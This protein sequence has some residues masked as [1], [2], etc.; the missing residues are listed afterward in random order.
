MLFTEWW[1]IRWSQFWIQ[2][3]TTD[4]FVMIDT[5]VHIYVQY[6]NPTL[7]FQSIFYLFICSVFFQNPYLFF[8]FIQLFRKEVPVVPRLIGTVVSCMFL[9]FRQK[10]QER[11]KE[12]R[13]N[14]ELSG[15]DSFDDPFTF[16]FLVFCGLLQVDRVSFHPILFLCGSSDSKG[17]PI[18]CSSIKVPNPNERPWLTLSIIWWGARRLDDTRQWRGELLVVYGL[19]I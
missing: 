11:K 10:R 17:E 12:V 18:E 15:I 7:E 2:P 8:F 1:T 19:T 9:C 13:R 5:I 6:L 3:T 16:F 4:W 14:S